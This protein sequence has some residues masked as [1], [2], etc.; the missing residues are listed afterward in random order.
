MSSS[1]SLSSTSLYGR[2]TLVLLSLSTIYGI[3]R[4]LNLHVHPY[5]TL[6]KFTMTA[7]ISKLIQ[8]L[9]SIPYVQNLISFNAN[10]PAC[11]TK[12]NNIT[13]EWVEWVLKQNNF[14]KTTKIKSVKIEPFDA[15]KTSKAVRIHIVYDKQHRKSDYS[16][17]RS[18]PA[19]LFC[20]MSRE[21]ISSAHGEHHVAQK[22]NNTKFPL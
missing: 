1:S 8:P 17:S 10:K 6:L 9:S 22:F 15:G 2:K 18:P 20:K 13:T 12:P 14:P 7:L 16:S 11:P 19:S 3:Y 21:G 5:V 4:M